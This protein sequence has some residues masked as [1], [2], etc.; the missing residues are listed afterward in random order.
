MNFI[1]AFVELLFGDTGQLTSYHGP[2]VLVFALASSSMAFVIL[3]L[4]RV[5]YAVKQK[6]FLDLSYGTR[7]WDTVRLLLLWSLGAGLGGLL[8]GESNIVQLTRPAAVTVGIGWPFILPRLIESIKK[9][10]DQ[11]EPEDVQI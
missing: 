10:E 7:A 3:L 8:G 2:K 1:E 11:Q 9:E 5:V 6:S 4:D